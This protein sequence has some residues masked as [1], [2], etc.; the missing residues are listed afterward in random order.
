VFRRLKEFDVEK[1]RI[2]LRLDLNV[3]IKEGKIKDDSRIKAALPTISYLLERGAKVVAASHLG[4]PKSGPAPEF[5]LAPVA[6]RLA[7]LL[8][9]FKIHFANDVVG[10]DAF[11]KASELKEGELLLLE[12]VRFEAGETKGN[13]DLAGKFRQMGDVYVTDAFGALHRAHASVFQAAK[14]FDAVLCGFLVEKEIRYLKEKLESPDRPYFALLGGAKVS[15]KIP[16]L[17]SLV[18]KVDGIAIGGAMAY[19]FLL[20]KGEKV[21]KSLIEPEM[22][23]TATAIMKRAL[24]RQIPFLLPV[25]H[26]I[27]S[28]IEDT[29]P[30]AS[31]VIGDNSSAFDI[32]PKTIV[33][34][35]KEIRKAKTIVW[36]GPMGVF[37]KEQ[38]KKGT[39]EIAR[40]VA[41]TDAVKIVGGGDS[42][43]AI[44]VAG[45]EDK[46]THISTGG[47]ASLELIAGE[48]LPGVE[49]LYEKGQ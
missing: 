21:G 8:P 14:L 20:A 33:L 47:G 45:V 15:D 10:D 30:I 49:I 42:V 38:F 41:E 12:N 44:K 6:K 23:G 7:E 35:G 13:E 39:V 9:A 28:S 43:S 5:S 4:R 29:A 37:E 22:V 34:F 40:A 25:D 11:R 16:I 36:N 27:A 26:I 3:P 18:E 1:K 24:E 31:D 46:I 2:F 17:K 32:G 19:T 48:K